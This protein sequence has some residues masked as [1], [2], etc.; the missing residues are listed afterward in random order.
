MLTLLSITDVGDRARLKVAELVDR[1]LRAGANVNATNRYGV[2]PISLAAVN[3]NPAVLK[4]LL[5][6][7]ADPNSR[8]GVETVLI[9][10]ARTRSA[11]GGGNARARGGVEQISPPFVD[12]VVSPNWLNT[13]DC[14]SGIWCS[15]I[16]GTDRSRP[17]NQSGF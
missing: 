17:D 5:D 16:T 12:G 11:G 7:G 2:A 3:A 1:L 10:A 4:R 8:M 13:R 6:A 15:V 14:A 9:T